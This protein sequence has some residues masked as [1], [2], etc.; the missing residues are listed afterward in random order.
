MST[1]PSRYL[2]INDSMEAWD[3]CREWFIA[4]EEDIQER[5]YRQKCVE[6]LV[7]VLDVKESTV[8]KWGAQFEKMPIPYK[9]TLYLADAIRKIRNVAVETHDQILYST[10]NKLINN[11]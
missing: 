5:G 4:D 8:Q 9:R 1:V 11:D 10:L 3:F 7:Q 6:L 2:L